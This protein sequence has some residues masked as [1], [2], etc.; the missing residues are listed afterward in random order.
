MSIRCVMSRLGVFV[1]ITLL[2]NGC[3]GF[4]GLMYPSQLGG[5]SS[6]KLNMATWSN[7]QAIREY[8]DFLASGKQEIERKNDGPS[9]IVT[10]GSKTMSPL[11]RAMFTLGLKEDKLVPMGTPTLP[12]FVGGKTEYPIY[13]AVPPHKLEEFIKDL[14]DDWKSR[15]EDLCFFSGTLEAGC[16]E[17]VLKK[18]GYA[19]DSMTQCLLGGFTM[20]DND[21]GKPRDLSCKIGLDSQ[22][23]TKW[24]GECGACGKWAGA[25]AN[26]LDSFGIR[27]R[28][29]FYREWRRWMV[30]TSTIY[31]LFR[32]GNDIRNIYQNIRP[33][34]FYHSFWMLWKI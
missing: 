5:K 6:T 18:Y 13:V 1:S 27:C 28:V 8:Q 20:P 17:P 25:F 33:V 9:V 11:V 16:I 21:Y 3:Y 23:E 30:R 31:L 12:E 2:L 19:R 4:S 24:A 14:P 34:H 10:D 32:E 26:R 7:G 15:R 22:G 29:G